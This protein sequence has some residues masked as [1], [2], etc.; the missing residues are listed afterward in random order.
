MSFP[1]LGV[2]FAVAEAVPFPGFG[3]RVMLAS[4]KKIWKCYFSVF[5]FN[6]GSLISIRCRSLKVLYNSAG[7]PFDSGFYFLMGRFILIT[8]FNLPTC[9]KC[10]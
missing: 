7:N 5:A 4:D 10:V 6:F 2:S 8:N 1:G 3:V 9:F